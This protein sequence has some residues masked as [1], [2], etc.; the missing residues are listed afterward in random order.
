[1]SRSEQRL[2]DLKLES[3]CRSL[4]SADDVEVGKVFVVYVPSADGEAERKEQEH[5]PPEEEL[6]AS[7]GGKKQRMSIIS[8]QV[9]LSLLSNDGLCVLLV[10]MPSR[11]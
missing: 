8:C 7:N 3:V 2:F 1:M 10:V 4:F 9:F 11:F 6:P 5:V